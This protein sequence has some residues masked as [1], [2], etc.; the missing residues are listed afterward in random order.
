MLNI[1]LHINNTSLATSLYAHCLHIN[2]YIFICRE[3]RD[4]NNNPAGDGIV[5]FVE[6][7]DMARAISHNHENRQRSR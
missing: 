7:F 2:I 3:W 6:T 1:Y 5:Q 4:F